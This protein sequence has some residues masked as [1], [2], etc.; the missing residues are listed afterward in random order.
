MSDT[1]TR[2]VMRGRAIFLAVTG[3]VAVVF[4]AT[5]ATNSFIAAFS[6]GCLYGAAAG[7]YLVATWDRT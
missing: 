7:I 2:I 4:V 5:I 3:L 1:T 6:L